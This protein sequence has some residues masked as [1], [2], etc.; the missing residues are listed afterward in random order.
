VGGETT[1]KEIIMRTYRTKSGPFKERPYY[2]LQ[3]IEDICVDELQKVELLPKAPGPIR[4]ERF[5]E[6]KFGIVPK[7][8]D[9]PVGILGCTKFSVNGVEEIIVARSLAEGET[10]VAGRRI[11]TTLAHEVGHGLLHAYLFSHGL[12]TSSLFGDSWLHEEQKLICRNDTIAGI[13]DS[14]V[15][16]EGKWW[17]YQANLAISS[18]L[19]PKQLVMTTLEPFLVEKGCFGFGGKDLPLAKKSGAIRVVSDVFD[20]NPIVARIRVSA[21]FPPE[22]NKQLTM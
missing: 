2:K 8:E 16:Y 4:I 22:E 10:K 14:K 6:K 15:R 9:L 12:E 3:E 5:I 11:N 7:Y 21:M 17:E 18:L 13:K 20:V 19:L 1:F